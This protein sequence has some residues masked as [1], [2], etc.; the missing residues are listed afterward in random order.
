[1]MKIDQWSGING[2]PGLDGH[3][4]ACDRN[5]RVLELLYQRFEL[6]LFMSSAL[7]AVIGVE[8][9]PLMSCDPITVVCRQISSFDRGR[10]LWQV[11]QIWLVCP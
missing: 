9:A 4:S 10:S 5:G 2:S 7:S 6:D 8:P 3:W 1:M 11:A